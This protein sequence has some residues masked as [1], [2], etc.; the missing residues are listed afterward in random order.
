[1][2]LAWVATS[3]CVVG[4]ADPL[5]EGGGGGHADAAQTSDAPGTPDALDASDAQDAPQDTSGDESPEPGGDGTV[6]SSVDTASESP[7]PD[8]ST[9]D[10]PPPT[11]YVVF[12]TGAPFLDGNLGGLMGADQTCQARAAA[13]TP[14]IPGTFRA[15][16]SDSTTTA[17]SRA[18]P[19]HGSLPYVLVDGS[20]L[21]SDWAQ[22]TDP[23]GL[24]LQQQI[25]LDENG[26]AVPGNDSSCLD[27]STT[28]C[29]SY[30]GHYVW[31]D[32]SDDGSLYDA[33]Q[34]CQDWTSPSNGVDGSTGSASTNQGTQYWSSWCH[35]QSCDSMGSLYCVQQ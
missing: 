3:G 4:I 24:L 30:P 22:L 13:A 32:S 2:L 12:V 33:G 19:L 26:T 20:P 7:P 34:T 18:A 14:P 28:P 17:A 6:D 11:H 8:T 31:T 21:A 23:S 10:A 15:W 5:A 25:T 27:C 1:L 29:T 35:V 9:Q 16:L